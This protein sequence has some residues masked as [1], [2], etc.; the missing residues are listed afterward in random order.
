MQKK[1][2][3]FLSISSRL[4]YM[5]IL[6]VVEFVVLAKCTWL[7]KFSDIVRVPSVYIM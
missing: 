4:R 6:T 5:Q 2:E 3:I 1:N 7:S